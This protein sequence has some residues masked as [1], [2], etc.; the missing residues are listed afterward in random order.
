MFAVFVNVQIFSE[1][2]WNIEPI[3]ELYNKVYLLLCHS[4]E[5]SNEEIRNANLRCEKQRTMKRNEGCRDENHVTRVKK[6]SLKLCRLRVTLPW[7]FCELSTS[8]K[9]ISRPSTSTVDSRQ[10]LCRGYAYQKFSTSR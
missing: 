7:L 2:Q 10:K 6:N 4:I 8:N 3:D 5:R 1:R 9:Y